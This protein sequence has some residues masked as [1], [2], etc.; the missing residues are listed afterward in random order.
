MTSLDIA[1][2]YLDHAYRLSYFK[3]YQN[4][5]SVNIQLLR[6]LNIT[7]NFYAEYDSE[8]KLI[9]VYFIGINLQYEQ[10]LTEA[11]KKLNSK[12]KLG[13]LKLKGDNI[14]YSS[15]ILLSESLIEFDLLEVIVTHIKYTRKQFEKYLIGFTER[16]YAKYQSCDSL[17]ASIKNYSTSKRKNEVEEIE[18]TEA[19]FPLELTKIIEL[20]DNNKIA[21]ILF[22]PGVSIDMHRR[23]ISYPK[24]NQSILYSDYIKGQLNNDNEK[25]LNHI[26]EIQNQLEIYKNFPEIYGML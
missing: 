24:M 11:I 20:V 8:Y 26:Q 2:D 6:N 12:S 15:E 22:R 10:I 7:Y 1:I 9:F 17:I 19:S 21:D 3:P 18:Y 23:K 5:L 4:P 13:E 14:H 16:L 25:I